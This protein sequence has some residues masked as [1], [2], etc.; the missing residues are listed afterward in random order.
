MASWMTLV[1]ESM[2]NGSRS[3]RSRST[4]SSSSASVQ[5]RSRPTHQRAGDRE[6]TIEG[7]GSRRKI[8]MIL[9]DH[10]E[11][12]LE[13]LA[14]RALP[15]PFQQLRSQP[16]QPTSTVNGQLLTSSEPSSEPLVGCI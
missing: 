11:F 16:L 3:I 2:C 15:V 1:L 7:C 8:G 13:Q 12:Q 5:L 9:A 6:D 10:L 14:D 4:C